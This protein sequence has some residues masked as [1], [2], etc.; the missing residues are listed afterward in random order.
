MSFLINPYAF[1]AAGG[2]FESI[3]TVTVGSGGASSIE[4]TSIP[5]TFA[6]LQVRMLLR[7]DTAAV[8][9][10]SKIEIN[11]DT[12]ANYKGH[13][14]RG[15]GST[16]SATSTS[17]IRVHV[18]PAASAAANIFGACIIDIPDYANTSKNTT[19]RVLGSHDRNGAGQVNLYSGLWINT[20]AVTSLKFTDEG[21][22]NFVQYSTAAL[23]G[24]KAP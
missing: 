15:D 5:S 24:V 7:S 11:G 6:H 13:E 8:Q 9:S 16:A 17:G 1:L 3:A 21:A 23:F 22:G 2:D 4:F 19:V 12:G 20:S 10:T 18:T 14:L